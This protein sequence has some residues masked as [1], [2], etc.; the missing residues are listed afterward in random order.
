M[1]NLILL[2]I[3]IIINLLLLTK[4]FL[5][6]HESHSETSVYNSDTVA[7][8]QTSLSQSYVVNDKRFPNLE[9]R[10]LKDEP[11]SI[12]SKINNKKSLVFIY[13]QQDCD[14]CVDRLISDCNK[15]TRALQKPLN[16]IG[17]FHSNNLTYLRR[18]VAIKKN[19][20]FPIY[21]DSKNDA[22]EMLK[23]KSTPAVLVLNEGSKIVNSLF[24]VYGVW[25]MNESFFD[26]VL[27]FLK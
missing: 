4:M 12:K 15:L 14:V 13:S 1:R 27:N 16:I 8:I 18:F 25:E 19:I 2:I 10:N 3:M 9:F 11:F 24:P 22:K 21:W 7:A 20:N 5:F 6:S 26:F 17:I 23:L